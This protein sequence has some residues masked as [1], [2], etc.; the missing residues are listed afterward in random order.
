M[1]GKNIP[2]E[3]GTVTAQTECS[4]IFMQQQGDQRLEWSEPTVEDEDRGG[5]EI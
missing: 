4:G 2:R 5:A 3:D 1:Y